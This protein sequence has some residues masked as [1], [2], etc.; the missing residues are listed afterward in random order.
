MIRAQTFLL[1]LTFLALQWIRACTHPR[2]VFAITLISP[3]SHLF[4]SEKICVLSI[5]WTLFLFRSVASTR[6]FYPL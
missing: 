6:H 2:R 4:T 3:P 5:L 1:D